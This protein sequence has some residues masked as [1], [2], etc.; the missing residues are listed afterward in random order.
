MDQNS[1]KGGPW[2]LGVVLLALGILILIRALI[3]SA[4]LQWLSTG[5]L[6]FIVGAFVISRSRPV[7]GTG[8]FRWLLAIAGLIAL[9]ASFGLAMLLYP[10]GRGPGFSGAYA[11]GAV[12]QTLLISCYLSP[13]P[14]L[15]GYVIGR[16]IDTRT[17]SQIPPSSIG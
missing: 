5:T 11:A 6:L 15:G 16:W 17:P 10:P 14:A 8:K 7:K 1:S 4:S 2:V 3:G 9:P 13:I 12:G